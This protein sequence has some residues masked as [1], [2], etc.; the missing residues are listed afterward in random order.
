MDEG[1][2][3]SASR[4][5]YSF[6]LAHVVLQAWTLQNNTCP[7]TVLAIETISEVVKDPQHFIV[8]NSSAPIAKCTATLEVEDVL[9]RETLFVSTIVAN[10]TDCFHDTCKPSRGESEC[11]FDSKPFDGKFEGCTCSKGYTPS[12]DKTGTCVTVQPEVRATHTA[13]FWLGWVAWIWTCS[14]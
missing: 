1:G 6:L 5:A 14:Y 9:T 12:S 13:A 8:L 7:G 10:V 11:A 2:F 3:H 4:S